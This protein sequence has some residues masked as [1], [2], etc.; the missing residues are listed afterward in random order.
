MSESLTLRFA[1]DMPSAS[2]EV[3]SAEQQTVGRV[4][5][6]PGDQATL[7]VPSAEAF[8]QVHM[9][10]GATVTLHDPTSLN[11]EISWATLEADPSVTRK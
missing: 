11:R 5:L 10:S 2:V 6:G 1:T 8:V 3:V 9:P 7:D 4:W